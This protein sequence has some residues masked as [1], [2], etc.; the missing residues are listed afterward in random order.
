MIEDKKWHVSA[1]LKNLYNEKT[2]QIDPKSTENIGE[3]VSFFA[4]GASLLHGYSGVFQ[5][6]NS[7]PGISKGFLGFKGL[8]A[9]VQVLLLLLLHTC[10]IQND[11]AQ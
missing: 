8:M 4:R 5:G 11:S 10:L 7:I 2:F 1:I 9:T 6:I 3:G